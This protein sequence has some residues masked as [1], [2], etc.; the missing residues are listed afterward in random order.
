[1]GK[2][3]VITN[4]FSKQRTHE[5]TIVFLW[6]FS[7]IKRCIWLLQRNS[8]L[9]EDFDDWG[10]VENDNPSHLPGAI[11]IIIR[12]LCLLFYVILQRQCGRVI[13]DI[14]KR[15]C[16]IFNTWRWNF[17]YI[18][19]NDKKIVSYTLT[20]ICFNGWRRSRGQ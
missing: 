1:M 16:K 12:H 9:N 11:L 20:Y 8:E 3:E 17:E 7:G 19:Y 5:L 13:G 14:K 10:V 15:F 4:W 2:A 18:F 6:L